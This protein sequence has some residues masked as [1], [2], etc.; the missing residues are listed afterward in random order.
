MIEEKDIRI[1]DDYA[2]INIYDRYNNKIAETFVD[3]E[4]LD[5]IRKYN[6]RLRINSTTVGLRY[7]HFV[8]EYNKIKLLHRVILNLNDS[9]Q[10]VDHINHNGLDNRKRNLCICDNSV[11]S[12]N[13]KNARN[14][15]FNKSNNTWA[16]K[17]MIKK[18]SH[19]KSG[20]ATKEEAHIKGQQYK[21]WFLGRGPY[22][23]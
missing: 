4:D 19:S 8:D 20:Y 2:I 12:L 9:K 3:I 5:K 16:W 10:I 13:R 23:D 15:Y 14:T 22:P 6:L 7:I 17:V 18:R 21:Q 1:V 11:N